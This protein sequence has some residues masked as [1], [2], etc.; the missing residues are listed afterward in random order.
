LFSQ[1]DLR[2]WNL[3]VLATLDDSVPVTAGTFLLEHFSVFSSTYGAMVQ[4]RPVSNT[5]LASDIKHA[6][7]SIRCWLLLLERMMLHDTGEEGEDHS[8]MALRIWS[9]LWPPLEALALH[10]MKFNDGSAMLR[11]ASNGR[12]AETLR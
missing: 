6:Y 12:Q 9:E 2:S 4:P 10:V 11:S 7:I 8:N 5:S 1:L 3:L